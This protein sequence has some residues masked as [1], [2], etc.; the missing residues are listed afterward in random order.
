MSKKISLIA[1]AAACLALAAVPAFAAKG[2][3]GGGGGGGNTATIAFANAGSFAPTTGAG[4]QVS[5]AV[6]ANVKPS[7]VG[8]L[9]VANVCTDANGVTVSAEYHGVSNWTSGPFTTA[10]ANCTAS[11]TL[12]PDVWTPLKGGSMTFAVS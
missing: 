3:G 4:S 8:N 2:G 10:G 5:F 12:F 7:D 1:A 9:W 11:V 6:T